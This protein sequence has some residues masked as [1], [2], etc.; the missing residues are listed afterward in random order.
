MIGLNRRVKVFVHKEATDMRASYDSLY[1]KVKD[2]LKK[3]PFSGHLF[4]F[5]NKRR[6][7]CKCLLYDGTGFVIVA[8]RLEKRTFTKFNPFYKKEMIL[9]QAEFALFFEGSDLNKRF[10]ESPSEVKIAQM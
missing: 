4:I 6:K 2:V 3:N 5:V 10:I 1:K 7:S 9:T 8:K